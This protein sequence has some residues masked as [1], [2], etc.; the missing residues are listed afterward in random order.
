M[1]YNRYIAHIATLAANKDDLS[2]IV[3]ALSN[4]NNAKAARLKA[5]LGKQADNI[6]LS[7]KEEELLQL[8]TQFLRG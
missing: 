6:Q 8:A 5:R 7:D 1:D 3:N 4:V 2:D